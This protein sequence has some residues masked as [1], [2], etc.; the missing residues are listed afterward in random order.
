MKLK[1][2]FY[3]SQ[4]FIKHI[5]SSPDENLC[6]PLYCLEAFFGNKLCIFQLKLKVKVLKSLAKRKSFN[7]RCNVLVLDGTI[8][9]CRRC[10]RRPHQR[11]C[12]RRPHQRLCERIPHQ[13]R[14]ER[15]PHQRRCERIPHQRRCKRRPHKRHCKRRPHQRR[16][17]WRPH[18]ERR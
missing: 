8:R 3:F 14:C 15:I 10:K 16:S 2:F 7:Q 4:N 6:T 1:N 5:I 12:K 9:L 13:R 18:L 17:K 11:R